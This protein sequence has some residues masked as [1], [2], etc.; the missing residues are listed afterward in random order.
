MAESRC[1]TAMTTLRISY[2]ICEVMQLL[3]T[4]PSADV[5]SSISVECLAREPGASRQLHVEFASSTS[6]SWRGS[7]EYR[8]SQLRGGGP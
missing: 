7:A 1:L 2:R 3:E 8:E 4:S 5:I 6:M